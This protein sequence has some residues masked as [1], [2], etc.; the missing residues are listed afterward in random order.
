MTWHLL[1]RDGQAVSI[2]TVLA[3]PI[4]DDLTVLDLTDQQ[5]DDLLHGRIIW[6][7]GDFHPNPHYTSPDD[8]EVL[9]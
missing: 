5:A 9:G 4:P 6:Y 2:G 7:D 1:H 3:D 8:N